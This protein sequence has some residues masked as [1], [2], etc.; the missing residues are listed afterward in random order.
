MKTLSLIEM[1]NVQGGGFWESMAIGTLC[2]VVGVIAGSVTMG[3]GFAAG[4]VC[5]AI[6]YPATKGPSY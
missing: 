6:F 2:G 3:A 1:E 5:N 4:I